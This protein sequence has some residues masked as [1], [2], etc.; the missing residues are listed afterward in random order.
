MSENSSGPV[1]LPS[2]LAKALK[3]PPR[4]PAPPSGSLPACPVPQALGVQFLKPVL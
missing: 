1:V 2:P 4:P 3:I